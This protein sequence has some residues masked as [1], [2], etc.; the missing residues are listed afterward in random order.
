MRYA[1]HIHV[2][3]KPG[4]YFF[5]I[6]FFS[7]L[8]ALSAFSQS[9][10]E[11]KMRIKAVKAL[12]AG[13][14]SEAEELYMDL[15]KLNPSNPDYNYEMGLAIFEGG[16][17]RGKA[18]RYLERAITNTKSDSL[19]DMFL[20]AGRA[21]QHAG[22]F[23]LAIDYYNTY[24]GLMRKS[25]TD[26]TT[27]DFDIPRAIEMCKNGK[28]QFENNKDHIKIENMGERINSKYADYS[29][30]VTSDESMILFTSRRSNSTGMNI[31]NDQKFYEDIYYSIN[32]DGQWTL[33]SNLDSSNK[34]MSNKLNTE[35][36]DATIT[37]AGDETQLYIYRDLD[38]WI[39]TKSNG[40]WGS[41]VKASGNINTTRGF[42]PSVFITQDEQIMFVVSDIG[43]GYGGRDIYISKKDGTENW[44][45]LKNLGKGIN[46]KFDED[47]PFL[48]PDGNT[49]YFA[50]NGHNS[51]G[52]YDIFKS[53]VDEN[54]N[55]SAPEN[56]GPPINTPGHDRYF[57]TTDNGAIGYYA[58]DREGGYGETDIYR[59]ILDCKSVSATIIRGLVYSEDKN[60]PVFATIEIYDPETDELINTYIANKETGEYEMRLKTETTYKF[61]IRA[62]GYLPHD[63][64]FT[65]PQ[66]C[67]YYSLFQEIKIENLSDS[68][69]RVY[70]QRATINNAFFNVD[71]KMEERFTSVSPTSMNQTQKDSLRSLIAQ[72]FHPVEITNYIQ[73]LDILDP[74]GTKLSSKVIGSENVA[75]IQT[76]DAI[77]RGYSNQIV[78]ADGLYYNNLLPEARAEYLIASAIKPTEAYPKQQVKI[79]DEK[80]KDA[81]F[82][83]LLATLLELDDAKIIAEPMLASKPTAEQLA[84]AKIEGKLLA[85]GKPSSAVIKVFDL[86]TGILIKTVNAT[87]GA[88]ELNLKTGNDYKYTV[89]I[90]GYSIQDG[91][92]KVPVQT[93]LYALH[94]EINIEKMVDSKDRI[95]AQKTTVNNA[96]FNADAEIIKRYPNMDFLSLSITQIDSLRS[97]ITSSTDP[98]E[99]TK[100][101]KTVDI[102]DP[103]GTSLANTSIGIYEVQDGSFIYNEETAYNKMMTEA[104]SNLAA[105]R[106]PEA[107]AGYLVAS[108]IKPEEKSPVEKAA[109]IEKQLADKPFEALLATLPEVDHSKMVVPT[110]MHQEVA[111]NTATKAE[112]ISTE[113]AETKTPE[114]APKAE[115][116][117]NTVSESITAETKAAAL[118]ETNAAPAKIKDKIASEQ[119][120]SEIAESSAKANDVA[121]EAIAESTPATAKIKDK[122]ASEQPKT[123]KAENA[124]AVAEQTPKSNATSGTEKVVFRNILF[125]FDKADLREASITELQRVS[126]YL[127]TSPAVDLRIDGHADWIGSIEYNLALSE[128]RAKR[129]YY[130]IISEGISDKRLTYQYFGESLPIAPNANA[131]GTDNPDGRQLNRRVE[132]KLDETGTADNVI[133]KF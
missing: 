93:E 114:V 62:E 67:E 13:N 38:V 88:Y 116:S 87:S 63:G 110:E 3:A 133:L 57:V 105:E 109:S 126:S 24:R 59:I 64:E 10:E 55:F 47:A 75:M 124:A 117:A 113:V 2:P 50:S 125:D 77:S 20:Y 25:G 39:S 58:S 33:A 97:V 83:A 131:D 4:K 60:S 132:F 102:L 8:F 92:F 36:H 107:R 23:D 17:Y 94:Q 44:G 90:P 120:K 65:V 129:A 74:Q 31:A 1:D 89:Q 21:E 30:V 49:L 103:N 32:I 118:A 78:T 34:Y 15:L 79:I 128:Q 29:P 100:F 27:L 71:K 40:Q 66:Q 46:T 6:V 14:Y 45:T 9:K 48:T 61:I 112:N 104:D 22:N 123:E 106:M 91:T 43:S 115:T 127:H 111:E 70:A 18:A 76:R 99:I 101:V 12:N 95:Y 16:V 68:A 53:I 28:V 69:G 96:F 73:L 84:M 5:L 35:T 122:I 41:P 37:F 7:L 108:E 72:E 56:L 82:E 52:D 81:P 86:K 11:K 26:L 130:F 85:D 80:L 42:E 121:K 19:P 51:M 54:G 98:V 119:P